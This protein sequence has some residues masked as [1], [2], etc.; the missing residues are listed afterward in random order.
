MST[1]DQT[2]RAGVLVP[3]FSLRGRPGGSTG[4]GVGEIPDIV[5]FAR[6]AARAGFSVVQLLPVN[7]V[8]G[9]ET[10]PYA[11]SSAF[12]LDPV[13]LGLDACEDFAAIGG[14]GALTDED[15]AAI[16][17]MAD[18][19]TVR[20]TL[21]RALKGRLLQRAFAHFRDRE[22]RSGSARARAF[23]EFCAS[24][25]AW[26]D[27]YALFAALHD[28]HETWWRDWP[29]PLR[30]RDPAAL[31]RAR[32]E[33]A[34]AILG[35][36]WVQWQLDEQWRHARWV[37]GEAGVQLMGDLPFMVSIDS[38]DVWAH[39][40]AFELDKRV[41]TPPDAFSAEG[42]D[43]GLPLY[44]WKALEKTDFA[45]I[46][47][48][49]ARSAELY[50]LYRVDHVIGLYRTY[51]RTTDPQAESANKTAAGFSPPEEKDQI[52]LGERLLPILA[53]GAEVV[54]EDLGMVPDFLRP[55]L[56]KLGIPGYKV[57]R[58]EKEEDGSF[59]DPAEY[60]PLSVATNGTHDI[61]T[62]AEWWDTLEPEEKK[63]L[64]AV[65]GLTHLTADQPFDEAV[66]DALL[67]VVWQSPAAL[68]LVPFQDAL[69]SRE[70]V[71][72]PG[73]V[74]ETN[75]SYRTAMDLTALEADGATVD[76]LRRLSE[77]SGRLRP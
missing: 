73:T 48:R 2:R 42:Q 7:E 9:G 58:W 71:N 29:A 44:D 4:F 25:K 63:A 66:R 68:V 74:A 19:P 10:S 35:K 49:A 69:G 16:D 21:V 54:A 34:D 31:A 22:W 6:W 27:D 59:R 57:M 8:S 11:A 47:A 52:A 37:A 72:V 17:A 39:P 12:A 38:A 32:E 51:Y 50:G 14:R 30:D 60:P 43:W 56:T 15:R 13:Y 41:G 18:A 64:L 23:D 28:K 67:R 24:S 53:E 20:W 5:P 46:R 77:E 65:P 70:R 3:L 55:S 45:W 62:N 1:F 36:R 76:R 26:L 75:W 61:T 33:L 40:E